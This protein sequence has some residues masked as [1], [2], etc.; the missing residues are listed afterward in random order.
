VCLFSE[1]LKSWPR[2]N[3]LL[4]GHCSSRCDHFIGVLCTAGAGGFM[5]YRNKTPTILAA[6][7]LNGQFIPLLG[8][9]LRRNEFR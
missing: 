2:S 6:Y 9:F 4:S 3:R 8:I 5:K 1:I 7:V